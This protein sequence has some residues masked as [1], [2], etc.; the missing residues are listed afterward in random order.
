M[1]RRLNLPGRDIV[2]ENQILE[3]LA[4]DLHRP[5]RALIRLLQLLLELFQDGND[6]L[7]SIGLRIYSRTPMRIIWTA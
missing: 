3:L 1:Y 2:I 4:F 6:P 7:P 5:L